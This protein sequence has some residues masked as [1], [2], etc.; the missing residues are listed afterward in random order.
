MHILFYILITS[1]YHH[2]HAG[3]S[4]DVSAVS[5]SF[6]IRFL[7]VHVLAFAVGNLHHGY[8]VDGEKL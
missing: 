8:I 6:P 7:S 5:W 3:F 2:L 1:A 4:F